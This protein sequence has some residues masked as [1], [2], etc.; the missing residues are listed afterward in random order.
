MPEHL[1]KLDRL[2]SLLLSRA[3]IVL[4]RVTWAI[5]AKAHFMRPLPHRSC[6]DMP[7]NSFIN[8]VINRAL[9][10]PEVFQHR[11]NGAAGHDGSR[12]GRMQ[13]LECCCKYVRAVSGISVAALFTSGYSRS[14]GA[15]AWTF[16][17]GPGRAELHR[18]M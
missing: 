13:C 15:L 9:H 5:G 18:S 10:K 17:S 12:I 1:G 3:R 16:P 7:L 2:P 11:I 8:T 6:E 14:I 4:V